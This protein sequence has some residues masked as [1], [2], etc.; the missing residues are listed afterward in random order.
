MTQRLNMPHGWIFPEGASLVRREVEREQ[1]FHS[2]GKQKTVARRP[3][4]LLADV[5]Y[6]GHFVTVVNHS[7]PVIPSRYPYD[8]GSK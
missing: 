8:A 2:C 6:L 3:P 1:R 4:Y 5:D 7:L